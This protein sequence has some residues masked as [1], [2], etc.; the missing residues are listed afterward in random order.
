MGFRLIAIGCALWVVGVA[1]AGA[2]ERNPSSGSRDSGGASEEVRRAAKNEPKANAKIQPARAG[3]EAQAN[4]SSSFPLY[5]PPNNRGAV[6]ARTGG[7]SRGTMNPVHVA[8]LAPD[9]IG[10]TTREHP[11]FAWVLSADTDFPIEVTLI[12]DGAIEPA[13]VLHLPGPQR[14]GIHQVDLATARLEPDATYEWTVAL[15]RDE[16][17]RDRDIIAGAAIRRAPEPVQVR[18]ARELAGAEPSYRVLARNG[19]WYDAI[20]DLSAAIA[21]APDDAAALRTQRAE[22][23]A[24]VGIIAE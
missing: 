22:L 13:A 18:L 3:Q 24:Q 17:S 8:P 21:A 12:A 6:G 7:G 5:V 16:K 1:P 9:H 14:A 23:L 4:R 20:A 10:L 2:G 15:V 19:I 11:T